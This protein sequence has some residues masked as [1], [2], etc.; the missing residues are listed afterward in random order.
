MYK[1]HILGMHTDYLL[2]WF[3]SPEIVLIEIYTLHEHL[4]QNFGFL[5]PKTPCTVKWKFFMAVHMAHQFKNER[6]F[7]V[8]VEMMIFSGCNC[9]VLRD[10]LWLGHGQYKTARPRRWWRWHVWACDYIWQ[11]A[12]EQVCLYYVVWNNYPM[13]AVAEV[14]DRVIRYVCDL[15]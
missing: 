3:L 6:A 5:E 10:C 7:G 13:P 4:T 9:S 1:K 14:W 12:T 11:T 8:F 15:V 2:K